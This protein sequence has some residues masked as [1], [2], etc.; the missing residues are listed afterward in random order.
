[1]KKYKL[2]TQSLTTHNGFQWEPGIPRTASG[3]GFLYGPGWLHYYHDP[4]I[5][6]MLNPIH[7]DIQDPILWLAEMLGTQPGKR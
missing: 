6:V 3:E 1:M 7:A 2:T 4:L 5:A